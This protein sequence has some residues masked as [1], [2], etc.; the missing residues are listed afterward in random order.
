MRQEVAEKFPD[1]IDGFNKLVEKIL[2]Y[3]A[4]NLDDG[5]RLLSR[6]V[7][8]SFISDPLL[9]D[10]LFCPLMYYGNAREGD[11]DFY[12]FVVMFNAIFMEGFSK[13][14]GG[15]PFI[16]NLLAEKFKVLGGELKMGNGVKTINAKQGTVG[17]VTLENEEEL[18]TEAVLSSMGYVETLNCCQPKLAE[19]GVCET[20][21]VSFMESLFVVDREPR[22][23]GYDK[24]IVFFSIHPRFDYKVPGDL[25]DISSGVLCCSNNFQYPQPLEEGLIRLTNLAHFGKWDSLPRKDY[26]AAKKECRAKALDALFTFFPDFRD[27]VVFLDVSQEEV[28]KRLTARGRVDDKPDVI[29]D[30]IALY[31]KET[32]PVVDYYRDKPGFVSIKAEGDTPESIAKKIINKVKNK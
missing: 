4:L 20:G 16:L 2:A 25:I 19:A 8:E 10:M 15:M 5:D 12:Q 13:P 27:N 28:I 23:L 3:D 17:S 1:Q 9:I 31:K 30:R 21:Q 26:I 18:A 14:Q 22:D 7:L 32:G 11:M 6:P 24:S 29:K